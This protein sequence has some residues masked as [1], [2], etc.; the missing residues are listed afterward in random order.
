MG[1][2]L[3]TTETSIVTG[4]RRWRIALLLGFGVIVNYFDRV[5]LSVAVTPLKGEFHL[6]TQQIGWLL[7]AYAWTYTAL[8]LPSGPVLDRFG[9]K[10]VGRVTTLLWSIASFLTGAARGLSSL[11]GTRLLLGVA[12]A[13]SF[14]G[15]AKAIGTWFPRQE[16]GLATAIFD[17]SA[18][19]ANG[20]GIAL[21]AIIVSAH[22]WRMS[23]VIT[24]ALS[25]LYF[26]LFW[27][28][29][30]D[31]SEDRG[32]SEKER[33]HISLGGA[34]LETGQAASAASLWYLLRRKK[35]WG[36]ALGMM[37]YNYNFYLFVTWLPGY[38]NTSLRLNVLE[39]GFYAAVPWLAAT[40]ADLVVGGWLVDHLVR[41]GFNA[42]RIRQAILIAGLV[43]GLAVVGAARATDPR[44]AIFWI[45]IA[46]SGLAASAPVGWSVPGLIAPPGAIARVGG[47][48]NFCANLPAIVAPVITGYL[49]GES[50]SFERA[51]LV[52]AGMLIMGIASYLFLLG[53]IEP[54][55]AP[56]EEP[57]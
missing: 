51:F 15:N 42:T 37:A 13:P 41:K 16:R 31:P 26:A 30:K 9:V 48:M 57:R 20:I 23:F 43:F 34:E 55:P 40:G 54:I 2:G 25:F 35:V 22:G 44:V 45:S 29:Y 32:L 46:L 53:K 36:L 4:H 24:G 1:H 52:A 19:F 49:V 11:I 50:R 56:Q 33:T 17:A 47:I 5:N 39:S 27:K 7:A 8:Q 28:I 21:I 12:E 6:T 10:L 38:L 18:K 14:P 3:Q